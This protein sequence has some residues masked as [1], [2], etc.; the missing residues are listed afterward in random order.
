MILK[1]CKMKNIFKVTLNI[2]FLLSSPVFS[3]TS[4]LTSDDIFGLP[5]EELMQHQ[6]SSVTKKLQAIEDTPAA[7]YII[8]AQDIQRAGAT[9]IADALRLAPG[10]EVGAIDNSKWAVSIRGFNSRLADKLLV[11]V[12]GHSIQPPLYPG[13]VWESFDLPL[14]LIERIEVL[15]GAGA[16]FWG[17]N[18]VNGVVNIITKSS[19]DTVG[20][21]VSLVVGT[22][23][24]L[25]ST[26]S[27]GWA[28]DSLTSFR[29]NAYSRRADGSRPARS[30]SAVDDNWESQR[31][32]LRLDKELAN[33]RALIQAGIFSA[34][35]GGEVLSATFSGGGLDVISED[36]KSH[37][38]HLQA[39]IEHE[40][41]NSLHTFQVFIEQ[42]T[43]DF[44]TFKDNRKTID[45][46]YQQQV[47]LFE[48][49]DLTWGTGYRLWKDGNLPSPYV[50][51]DGGIKTSY[52]ANIFFQDDISLF[53]DEVVL[54]LGAR[55]EKKQNR[56]H[57]FQPNIRL[58]WTPDNDNSLWAAVSRVKRIPTRGEE[59]A[60]VAIRPPSI[61][62]F[63]LAVIKDVSPL[64]SEELEAL[65]FGWRRQWTPLLSTDL[66]GFIYNY[67]D[68]RS[69]GI[70]TPAGFPPTH[71]SLV[72]TN[73][74]RAHNTGV[75]LSSEW[76]P[77]H[78]WQFK[79]NYSWISTKF[80]KSNPL[81]ST[82][83]FSEA[84]PKN[85]ISL[86]ASHQFNRKLE[87]S[88]FLRYTDNITVTSP[89]LLNGYQIPS[90]I[91]LNM[92]LN[93]K[94]S[95]QFN[96]SIVGKDLLESSHQ[97]FINDTYAIPVSDI[98]RS[99]YLKLDW[100]F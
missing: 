20:G 94:V 60:M 49:H 29:V 45:F 82:S 63:G 32:D 35:S 15:R 33:G 97:E 50:K 36:S 71:L 66:T 47:E 87:W 75:E 100:S 8:T 1:D 58:L 73:D 96:I 41:D 83:E 64:K 16:A 4:S 42:M 91:S 30:V 79:L 39:M 61:A 5:L 99:V 17:K 46:E 93:Y 57:E 77:R 48:I 95:E 44:Q 69:S 9:S 24:K 53:E 59:D 74:T 43:T 68:L 2:F 6:I 86:Q 11:L 92:R 70:L 13:T 25:I 3:K 65:D 7:A 23:Q 76:R 51:I 80:T 78:D 40:T 31:L 12:D 54:T 56:D 84:S 19:H 89:G 34:Q 72:L 26:G 98:D 88:S 38:V 27:Y 21:E 52:L 37:G 85:Q 28:L 55:I 90:Y 81:T 10:V 18:A 14:D 22:A 62:T 67:H